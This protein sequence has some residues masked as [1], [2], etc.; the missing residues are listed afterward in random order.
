MKT[1]NH[2]PH[3]RSS[4]PRI[5]AFLL[6]TTLVASCRHFTANTTP[7][8]TP[9]GAYL[10]VA[11]KA[12]DVVQSELPELERVAAIV[13]I[14]HLNGGEIG[15]LWNYQ[16]LQQE[17]M[18]RSG[19]MVCTGF[20]RGWKPTRTDAEKTNDVAIIGWDRPPGEHELQQIKD[21]KARG[22]YTIGFGPRK[23]AALAPHRALCD[24]WFDT[25]FGEDDRVVRLNDGTMAGRGNCLMNTLH[26]WTLTAEIVSALTRHGKMPT[27]WKSYAYADG[28]EWGDRYLGKMQFHDD[29]YVAP[30]PPGKLARDYLNHIRSYLRTFQRTQLDAVEKSADLIAKDSAQGKKT[31]VAMMGHMPWTFVGKY[32]DSRWADPIELDGGSAAQ[33]KDY[34]QKTPDGA[35]VLRLGYSGQAK[36]LTE[37]FEQKHQPELLIVAE[38]PRPEFQIP[39]NTVTRIDMGWEFG[40][41]CVSIKGY[42]IKIFPPSGVMQVV[43]YECV[44]VEVLERLGQKILEQKATK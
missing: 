20:E 27:M 30:I 7:P 41:A 8:A 5:L 9:S 38:N 2:K 14:R 15:F 25:G 24:A 17:L 28:H 11:F 39:S 32:E 22:C 3:G 6:L 37:T 23:M 21:A 10:D 16:S 34:A 44:N 40:D 42:P 4:H 29:Y 35:L 1:T 33:D 31:V 18:G 26:G 43:A 13:A 12:C 36:D 19:G